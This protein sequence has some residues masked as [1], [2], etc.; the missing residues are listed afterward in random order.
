MSNKEK[1][2]KQT[3]WEELELMNKVLS[4]IVENT[5]KG[6]ALNAA[7]QEEIQRDLI[8]IVGSI[9]RFS[10]HLSEGTIHE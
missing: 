1:L 3:A 10:D 7:E 4:Q 8:V 2:T 5:K 6:T 9:G